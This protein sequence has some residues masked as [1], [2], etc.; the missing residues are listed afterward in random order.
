MSFTWPGMLWALGVIPLVLW[1]AI[2]AARRRRRTE[3]RLADV[4]LYSR[5]V[6][7]VAPWRGR[8]P[9]VLYMI[10]LALLLLAMARPVAAIPLPVNRAAVM[11]TIDT[12]QSMMATDLKPTR[13]EAAK[14]AAREVLRTLPRSVQ[15]GLVAF[16]DVGTVLVPPSTDR[17]TVEEA[18]ERL[19]PQQSTSVGSALVEALSALP[20]RK[21]F[22]GSRLMQLRNTGPQDPQAQTQ[23]GP[24]VGGAP[25]QPSAGDLPPAVIIVFSDGVSNTGVDPRIPAALAV[26]A[27]VKIHAVGFGQEGG[28]VMPYGGGL[29]LVPF[30]AA[31]LQQLAQQAGGE[32]VKSADE[33]GLR[34]LA[35]QIGYA[36]GWER[37]RAEVTA[38]FAGAAGFLMLTGAGLSLAW[39]RRVP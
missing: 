39:F 14:T 29:I 15:V 4:H 27:R 13:L 5:I 24:P 9:L 10:A 17:P 37:R 35:R 11:L 20:D 23:T 18:L 32:Y 36:L 16:S 34:R 7:P 26:E 6:G 28:A 8:V 33:E 38:V 12:S 2:L 30:D 31:S 21:E 3:T 22:L 25:A 1:G 19:Q